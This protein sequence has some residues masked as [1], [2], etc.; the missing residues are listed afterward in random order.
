VK[1]LITGAGG[2]DGHYLRELL[3]SK[4]YEVIG[5]D[6]E[7]QDLPTLIR[8]SRPDEV[9][10][11]AAVVGDAWAVNADLGAEC[12]MA[13]EKVGAKFFQASTCQMFGGAPVQNENT[14]MHPKT[15]YAKA[16][17]WMH[18]LVGLYR[19]SGAYACSGILFNHESPLRGPDFVTQKIA[20]GIAAILKRKA[21]TIVLGNL[22][23]CRDWGHA[24]DFVRAMWL[25][26][27]QPKPDDYVIATGEMRSVRE[28]CDIAFA[29]VGL[30]YR[31]HV[32]SSRSLYRPHEL[33]KLCGDASKLKALGWSPRVSFKDMVKELVDAA[34]ER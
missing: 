18:S 10:N 1:A 5:A 33:E 13:A 11:L 34:L 15:E 3:H 29:Y 26:L 4:G 31:E 17:L 32:E 6:R 22:D 2:Q 30:D 21:R 23:A 8:A 20:R 7:C 19:D 14:P 16:K 28:L 27:Q 24:S 9:Y 25:T 12:L